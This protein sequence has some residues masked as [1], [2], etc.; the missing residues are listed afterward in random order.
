MSKY[1]NIIKLCSSLDKTKTL[2]PFK[3][4][5]VEII[6]L[7]REARE[8]LL[9][10][11]WCDEIL[12][13]WLAV[14]FEEILCVFLYKISSNNIEVDEYIWTI[15]GDLPPAYIDVE[16]AD[17][18]KDVLIGYVD[19]MSDWV[20]CVENGESIDEC[21]PIEIEPN[22]KYAEMLKGRLQFIS[23]ELLDQI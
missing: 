2:S 7:E 14:V 6:K 17:N 15:V 19:I 18:P 8:Y 3:K 4:D 21:Y 11:S 22:E 10:Y 16:S 12:D 1:E 5:D 23:S 9:S 13:G 20:K